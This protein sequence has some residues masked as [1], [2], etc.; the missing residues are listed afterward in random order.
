[1]PFGETIDAM[2]TMLPKLRKFDDLTRTEWLKKA[3]NAEEEFAPKSGDS[4]SE[5]NQKDSL[6][7]WYSPQRFVLEKK[8]LTRD[9]AVLTDCQKM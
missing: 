2:G 4:T 9:A 6:K 3:S 8:W 7:R 1:M 5:S